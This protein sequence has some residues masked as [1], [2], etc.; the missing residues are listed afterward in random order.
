VISFDEAGPLQLKPVG[1]GHWLNC[2][3][4]RVPATYSRKGTRQL[5]PAFNY[6][7]GTLFGRMRRRKT[8][9]NI[10][11]FFKELQRHYPARQCIHIIYGQSSTRRR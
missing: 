6:Y 1:G 11:S 10:F 4:D 8:A 3:P 9:K 7:H 2:N 5:L